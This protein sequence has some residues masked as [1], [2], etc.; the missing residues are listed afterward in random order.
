MRLYTRIAGIPCQVEVEYHPPL[1]GS[2]ETAGEP[3]QVTIET[4]FDRRGRPAPWLDDKMTEAD[5]ERIAREAF[6]AIETRRSD[7]IYE[8]Y[9]QS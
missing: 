3:E 8:R 6:S 4:V 9:R 7:E 2:L 5:E 1:A